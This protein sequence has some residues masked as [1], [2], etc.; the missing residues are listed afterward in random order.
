MIINATIKRA[1]A[2]AAAAAAVKE[3]TEEK[4]VRLERL[5]VVD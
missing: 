5:D 2:A 1:A 4:A 3:V